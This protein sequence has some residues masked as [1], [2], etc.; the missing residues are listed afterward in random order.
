MCCS[1]TRNIAMNKKQRVIELSIRDRGNQKINN[2]EKTEII[3]GP[4]ALTITKS[5]GN[6]V[7]LAVGIIQKDLKTCSRLCTASS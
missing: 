4:S 2:Q 5:Q 7:T 6:Q 3:S 1:S